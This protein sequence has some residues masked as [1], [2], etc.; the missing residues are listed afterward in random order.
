MNAIYEKRAS[1]YWWV[2]PYC[3]TRLAIIDT[4]EDIKTDQNNFATGEFKTVAALRLV[5]KYVFSPEL[6][7]WITTENQRPELFGSQRRK[8][9]QIITRISNGLIENGRED[10]AAQVAQELQD[11]L[12]VPKEIGAA[13][14]LA[15]DL[16]A[17][18][19]CSNTHCKNKVFIPSIR[20][21][22][23]VEKC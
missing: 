14:L 13:F 17:S 6:G 22:K 1:G 3:A 2:C 19:V 23:V 7:A 18:I 12:T 21:A 8:R 16:P 20:S 5:E 15:P 11:K 9:R 4:V 10:K